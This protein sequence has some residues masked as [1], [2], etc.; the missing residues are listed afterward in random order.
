MDSSSKSYSAC[1]PL[2]LK[3]KERHQIT[4]D[5]ANAFGSFVQNCQND[6]SP[7]KLT[8]FRK[9]SKLA[10]S[11]LQTLCPFLDKHYFLLIKGRLSKAKILLTSRRP[12]IVYAQQQ[13]ICLFLQ[14]FP[15]SNGH[16][17]LEHSCSIVQQDFWVF[18]FLKILKINI[19]QCLP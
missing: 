19:R 3:A 6:S 12:I 2:C 7:R 8:A 9:K 1:K 16:H 4:Q 5:L 11:R 15:D 17:G 13:S 18:H 10:R 14:Y